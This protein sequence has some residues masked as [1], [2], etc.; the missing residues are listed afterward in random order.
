MAGSA[1]LANGAP[2]VCCLSGQRT[3][4]A[5]CL[6]CDIR[7]MS[8]CG[9]LDAAGLAQLQRQVRHVCFEPGRTI[10]AE[11]EAADRGFILLSG[12]VSLSK[13]MPDGRRQVLG[14]LLPGDFIGI[15]GEDHRYCHSA[16]AVIR[17]ELCRFHSQT[18][19]RLADGHS[20]FRRRLTSTIASELCAAQE[21]ML[22]LGR[23]SALERVA[24]FLVTLARRSERRGSRRNDVRLPMTRR[25]IADCLGLTEASVTRSLG[26][27]ATQGLVWVPRPH[28]VIILR[29]ELLEAVAEGSADVVAR[30][31]R[32]AQVA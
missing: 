21:H 25:D 7:H 4:D 26:Q 32:G 20:E 17:T 10:V 19:E 23:K 29:R 14:F 5:P 2:H 12:M 22:W 16:E 31:R 6:H 27:L 30:R 28:E 11:G 13:S 18:L 15:A 3:P 9:A 24:S 8:V 1:Q